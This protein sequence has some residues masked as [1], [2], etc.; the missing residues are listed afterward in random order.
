[1]ADGPPELL[2]SLHARF[3][4]D[5]VQTFGERS[6]DFNESLVNL[7]FEFWSQAAHSEMRLIPGEKAL[8]KMVHQI[9]AEAKRRED[10]AV[11]I[12]SQSLQLHEQGMRPNPPN[13]GTGDLWVRNDSPNTLIYT[14][15]TGY[16]HVVTGAGADTNVGDA[17]QK[18]YENG[19]DPLQDALSSKGLPDAYMMVPVMMH[20]GTGQVFGVDLLGRNKYVPTQRIVHL[21]SEDGFTWKFDT[22][23][24]P[25]SHQDTNASH[26]IIRVDGVV[27][28]A[29]TDYTV[30][31]TNYGTDEAVASIFLM[32]PDTEAEVTATYSDVATDYF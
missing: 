9:L 26:V 1:M 5:L 7:L 17:L 32:V 20:K 19:D 29:P 4:E 23:H 25:P 24:Q 27:K 13:L 10:G 16:D 14:D 31:T 11:G 28:T 30:N 21:T 8:T 6:K 18:I 2:E 12:S 3:Q 22:A 15:D